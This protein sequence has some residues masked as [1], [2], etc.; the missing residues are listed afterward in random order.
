MTPLPRITLVTPSYNQAAY[1]ERTIRSVID[2]DYPALQYLI[3]D[4]GST[5]GS[6]EIIRRYERHL[7]GWVSQPDGG[8]SDAINQGFA[9]AEGEIMTWLNSDDVLLPGALRLVGEIFARWPE[10]AWLTGQPA[11]LDVDD[12]LRC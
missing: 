9:R 7:D 12:H 1:L 4:G 8:Q 3:M 6:V 10:I 2:Q 5:D 11:N